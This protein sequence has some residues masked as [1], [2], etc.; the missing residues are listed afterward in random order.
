MLF[1]TAGS[2]VD[3]QAALAASRRP[4]RGATEALPFDGND[5]DPG[6]RRAHTAA[7]PRRGP[8]SQLGHERVSGKQGIIMRLL[9]TWRQYVSPLSI[10]SLLAVT[11][12]TG[13]V[14]LARAQE[15]KAQPPD[16]SNIDDVLLGADPG[17]PIR[18]LVV[19]GRARISSW[20]PGAR[21]SPTRPP[22]PPMGFPRRSARAGCSICQTTSS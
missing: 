5:D 10:A 3:Q 1:D 20:R 9:T 4:R 14:N 15:A 22:I 7:K 19:S 12:G 21:P 11:I 13:S 2:R 16:F 8:P 18:D 6:S 17:L